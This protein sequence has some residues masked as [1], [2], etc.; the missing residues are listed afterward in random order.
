MRTRLIIDDD[1]GGCWLGWSL[2]GL[3]DIC[4]QLETSIHGCNYERHLCDDIKHGFPDLGMF[5]T[6]LL[7]KIATS[8][9]LAY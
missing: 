7:G 6:G 3:T 1:N 9:K 4:V 5:L 8:V 2:D